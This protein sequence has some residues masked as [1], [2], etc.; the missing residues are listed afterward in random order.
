[1]PE[2]KKSRHKLRKSLRKKGKVPITKHLKEFEEGDKV[3]IDIESSVKDGMPHPKFQGKVG[4]V[5]GKQ[6]RCY[7]VK[8]KD[9]EGF[10][11]LICDPVH[12][13]EWSP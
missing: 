11:V 2:M 13:K 12:V 10:K 6:G 9:N 1:M 7:K 3:I 5:V 4:E 8:V